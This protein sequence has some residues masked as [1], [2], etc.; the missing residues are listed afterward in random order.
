M[1]QVAD[2]AMSQ[3]GA[4]SDKAA[5]GA[6]AAAPPVMPYLGSISDY[7]RDTTDTVLVVEGT[8]LPCHLLVLAHHSRVFSGMAGLLASRE[9]SKRVHT[10]AHPFRFVW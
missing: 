6:T 2:S 9:G 5:E 8:E 1:R 10:A 3:R 7:L 4:A